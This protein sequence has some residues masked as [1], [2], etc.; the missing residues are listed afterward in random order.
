MSRTIT[1]RSVAIGMGLTAALL[2]SACHGNRSYNLG[3]SGEFGVAGPAGPQ[4]EQGPAGPAGPQ[5]PQGEPGA[6]GVLGGA[7]GGLIGQI[8]EATDPLGRVT[9]GDRTV[10]G[11]ADG[12]GGPLGVSVLSPTQNAGQAA[13]VGVLSGG[14][15]ATVGLGQPTTPVDPATGAPSGLLGLNVGGNQVLGQGSGAPAVDLAI[16]SPTGASGTAVTG[17]V[18]SNG[19]PLAVGVSGQGA[20]PA[21]GLVGTV[22]DKVGGVVGTVGGALGQP[23]GGTA[24]QPPAG[25]LVGGLL[26]GLGKR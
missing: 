24:G 22:T 1:H 26:G 12:S 4:G 8:A 21:Q 3:S 16:L 6:G 19:Q 14:N 25:G 10:V 15:V 13:T 2:L 5:G 18:L 7:G 11:G 20:A 23:T 9:I 17:N